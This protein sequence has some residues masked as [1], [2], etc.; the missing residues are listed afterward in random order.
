MKKPLFL[1]LLFVSLTFS[2]S[3]LEQNNSLKVYEKVDQ[4]FGF[5][6]QDSQYVSPESFAGKVYVT[7]FFFSTCPTICPKM[8]EQM[9]TLY[10]AF[11]GRDDFSLLSH[12][13]DTKHD[14][15]E[16]LR[17]YA[18]RLGVRAPLWHFVT[19]KK[20]EIYDMAGHYM[21]SA[22]EDK[23]APGGY[24]HSGSLILVDKEK[25]IRGY[26]DGTKPEEA[27]RLIADVKKLLN[28]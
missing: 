6:N 28:E 15:V 19:G 11:E 14:T 3:K 25:Q 12:T 5:V 17:D 20:E 27:R 1:V 21:V 9:L 4:P 10:K 16:V 24:I 23:N 13:I 2:C 22:L 18:A 26:Y 7:D 8:K